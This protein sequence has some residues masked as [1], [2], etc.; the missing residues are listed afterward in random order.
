MELARR[1]GR[2]TPGLQ[3]VSFDGPHKQ[4]IYLIEA[5]DYS[6]EVSRIAL[7]EH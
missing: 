6:Q 4:C 2:L 3:I 7:S 5:I 1:A